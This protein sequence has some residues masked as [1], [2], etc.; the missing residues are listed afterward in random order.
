MRVVVQRVK[1]A[2][3]EIDTAIAG[4]IQQG[5]LVYLG[6]AQEDKQEDIDWLIKKLTQL[7][8]FSDEEEKMNLN[9][10]DVEGEFLVVSQFTL[11]ASTKKGNRPSFTE[12]AKPALANQL[13][14][15][16]VEDLEVSMGV[17]I[18][19]G[20]FGAHM[21]VASVNDGPLTFILDS[22]NKL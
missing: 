5:L 18:Q 10:K 15:K 8:V 19:T 21:E 13:Y 22:K 7:R 17:R 2:S 9:I 1:E 16:F 11:H 6:I 12:A 14:E 4:S 3:V 20:R